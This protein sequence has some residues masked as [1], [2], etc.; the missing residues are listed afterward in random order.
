MTH[1]STESKNP[2]HVSNFLLS[3]LFRFRC[4]GEAH[5]LANFFA[6]S[7]PNPRMAIV[8]ISEI[9]VN[10]IE[11]GNLGITGNE[12]SKLQHE[13]T[14]LKEIDRRLQL[15]EHIHQYVEVKFTRTET[16]ITLQVTDQGK[17]FNW[18]EID[19]ERTNTHS[20]RGRGIFMANS[21]FKHLEYSALGNEV[22]CVIALD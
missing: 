22:T 14:W 11:H 3:G 8:A 10:A 20:T 12:K 4:L 21:V 2:I 13:N 5:E 9:L 1:T 17:G 6:H 15:P 18:Q 19:I 7:C 16:E